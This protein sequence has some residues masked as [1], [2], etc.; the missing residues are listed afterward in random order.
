LHNYL[1][2]AASEVLQVFLLIDKYG[3]LNPLGK[4]H[5]GVLA[6][7]T[8]EFV[9]ILSGVKLLFPTQNAHQFSLSFFSLKNDESHPPA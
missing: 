3:F 4:T 8:R 5:A 2:C 1:L 9:I 7:G 6:S